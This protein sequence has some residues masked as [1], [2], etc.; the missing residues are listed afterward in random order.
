M[1]TQQFQSVMTE[2]AN[3]LGRE[4]EFSHGGEVAKIGVDDE[5]ELHR[6]KDIVR[7]SRYLDR[8]PDAQRIAESIRL[9][10]ADRRVRD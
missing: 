8:A 6:S 2:T 3:L 4:V 5:F 1:T 10:E 9:H 7:H